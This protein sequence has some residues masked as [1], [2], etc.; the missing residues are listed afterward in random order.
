MN[1]QKQSVRER[2]RRRRGIENSFN[3]N[4]I[5]NTTLF[6]HWG[7]FFLVASII[8][9]E[10]CVRFHGGLKGLVV[11]IQS[12]SDLL[13]SVQRLDFPSDL[14]SIISF[15]IYQPESKYYSINDQHVSEVYPIKFGSQLSI[16]P[17]PYHKN[18]IH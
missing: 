16:N 5:W 9:W 7:Y 6:G 15:M 17:L 14:I 11:Y 13:P 12:S 8:W 18:E 2:E 3:H 1:G 4:G 10:F